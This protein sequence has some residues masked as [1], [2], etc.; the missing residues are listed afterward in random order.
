MSKSE[1]TIDKINDDVAFNEEMHKYWN[2]KNPDL[3]YTSVTTI[4]GKYHEKFDQDFWSSYKAIE[5]IVGA[6]VFK[7][8]SIKK[9]LL[10]VKKW[11]DK[12]LDLIDINKEFFFKE[13]DLISKSY[14]KNR[15]E[16]CERGTAYHLQRE[17]MFYE[18]PKVKLDKYID[19]KDEFECAKGNWDLSREKALLPEYLIYWESDCGSLNIAGQIDVLIKDC[20]SI[21][22]L[23]F[24][25][26]AKGIE[27][28]AYYN[29]K[30]KQNKKMYYPIHHLDDTTFNHYALQLSMYAYMIKQKNPKFMVKELKLLHNAG[31]GETIIVCPYLEKEVKSIINDLCKCNNVEREREIL[32]QIKNEN[33]KRNLI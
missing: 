12:Y 26:N 30:T 7:S 2:V 11:D 18:K 17:N 25:S 15:E 10:E 27:T 33:G 6:T 14:D 28:K 31:E 16:A 13:K 29:P 8:M 19:S 1:I 21:S 20:D 3:K 9:M 5:K 24:K 22:V 4:I 32:S 23:D